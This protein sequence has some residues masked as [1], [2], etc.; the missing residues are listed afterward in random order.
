MMKYQAKVEREQYFVEMEH[1]L[2]TSKRNE[3]S[4]VYLHGLWSVREEC[5]IVMFNCIFSSHENIWGKGGTVH[6]V[7]NF[8]AINDVSSALFTNHFTP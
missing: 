5:K 7:F 3:A 2:K 1:F 4:F 8:G 6:G